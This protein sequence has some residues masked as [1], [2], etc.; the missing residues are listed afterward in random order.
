MHVKIPGVK[1]KTSEKAAKADKGPKIKLL[2]KNYSLSGLIRYRDDWGGKYSTKKGSQRGA[3]GFGGSKNHMLMWQLFNKFDIGAGWTGE[4]DFIGAKD[5]DGDT[6]T[7]GENTVGSAD[8]NKAYA[9]G[10][11]LD[12]KVRFGRMKGS[13]IYKNSMIMGQYYQGID[14]TRSMGSKW[15][16][17]V[18]FGKVDYNTA[19]YSGDT[20]K[21]N[22]STTASY[23]T[24]AG[25][26]VTVSTK[27]AGTTLGLTSMKQN[28]DGTYTG[29][30]SSNIA[31][32]DNDTV[33]YYKAERGVSGSDVNPD[34]LGVNMTQVQAGYQATKALSFDASWWHLMSRGDHKAYNAKQDAI[35]KSLLNNHGIVTGKDAWSSY[36]DPD[37]GEIGFNWQA[38]PKFNVLGH[39][40]MTNYR[41]PSASDRKTFG[42]Q[43]KAYAVTF[44]WGTAAGAHPHSRQFQLDLIHQERY[45]GIKSSYDLK[46]KA[47]EGQRGF[48]ADY[49]YVPVTNVMLD[50]RWMHYHSLGKTAVETDHANQY[51]VQLYYYF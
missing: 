46:N 6:R 5:S 50:F 7:T 35:N 43:N 27:D 9:E 45:T 11:L 10:P 23:S 16:A 42:D 1:A 31:V 18:S 33:Y 21:I 29:K 26:S 22:S 36:P 17:S 13:T 20:S 49:R 30:A 48:I 37:I 4:L 3:D 41:T 24:K 25:K 2:P 34:G 38:T 28:A 51:R 8:V 12:G 19:V 40:A 44:K 15:K 14:Y 47:G 39:F 32:G